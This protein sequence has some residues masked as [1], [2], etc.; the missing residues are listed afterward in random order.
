MLRLMF[1]KDS[2]KREKTSDLVCHTDFHANF[3]YKIQVEPISLWEMVI[4]PLVFSFKKHANVAKFTYLNNTFKIAEKWVIMYMIKPWKSFI[5]TLPGNYNSPHVTLCTLSSWYHHLSF[6]VFVIQ[7][8][9]KKEKKIYI[10][11]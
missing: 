9:K 1:I 3:N 10:K 4:K 11:R 5:I 6:L 7:T 8:M 2:S